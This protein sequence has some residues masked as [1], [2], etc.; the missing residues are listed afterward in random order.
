MHCVYRTTSLGFQS[1]VLVAISESD[2]HATQALMR[3]MSYGDSAKERIAHQSASRFTANLLLLL[4]RPA[5]VCSVAFARGGSTRRV[6]PPTGVTVTLLL[7]SKRS[8][9]LSFPQQATPRC[10]QIGVRSLLPPGPGTDLQF[11][12]GYQLDKNL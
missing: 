7:R 2:F 1:G 4:Y 8:R 12:S 5:I 3:L 9:T 6:N 11:H 10:R